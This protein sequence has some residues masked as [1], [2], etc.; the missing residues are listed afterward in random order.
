MAVDTFNK[1][2]SAVNL[3][4]PFGRVGPNPDG[5]NLGTATEREQAANAYAFTINIS[6]GG[7]VNSASK[8]ASAVN[9]FLPFARNGVS[10][11]GAGLGTGGERTWAAFGYDGIISSNIATAYVFTQLT[12][13]Q[14]AAAGGQLTRVPKIPFVR[15]APRV[16]GRSIGWDTVVRQ[17]EG[18]AYSARK[19]Y[20]VYTF[21]GGQQRRSFFQE[22]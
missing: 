4:L 12:G 17:A 15:P 19:L 8:R 10:P 5:S 1:R 18:D 21:G 6:L 9:L 22:V 14:S 3:F 13:A 7:G 20:P 2:A 11:D 16:T